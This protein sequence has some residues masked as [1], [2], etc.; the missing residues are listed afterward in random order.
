M[1]SQTAILQ[2]WMNTM[3]TT[4]G[5][6][7]HKL[8]RAND[9]Y[10]LNELDI[11]DD[12][13]PASVHERLNVYAS[14]YVLRL[15]ECLA[16][17]F[18]MLKQW[19]GDDVF[20]RFAKAYLLYQPS[21]S[22][23]LY[24]LGAGFATFLTQTKPKQPLADAAVQASLDL[25]A[26]IAVLER[27]RQESM[28]A[29]GLEKEGFAEGISLETLLWQPVIITQPPCL[30]LVASPFNLLPFYESLQ[31]GEEGDWPQFQPS[32]IGISRVN[33]RLTMLTLEPWQYYFL[34]A[35]AQPINVMHAVKQASAQSDIAVSVLLAELYVWLP[36][37]QQKG[38][39]TVSE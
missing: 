14:G 5:P 1:P 37:F 38:M 26:A 31:K 25:P 4:Y 17:D 35:A 39:I 23:T 11:I 27:A 2:Q 34:Q 33:Y 32:F 12:E 20:F 36:V 8:Q 22:F 19:M 30:R 18:P 3:I 9:A 7:Q 10:Q 16:A 24:D 28:R 6:L 13:G 29:K 21:T 15:T